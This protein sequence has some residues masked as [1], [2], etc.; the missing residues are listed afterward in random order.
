VPALTGPALVVAALLALAGAQKVLDPTM[1]VGA[2]QA[3]R[4]PASP[5]VVRI[6]AAA[7]LALGTAAIGLGGAALWALVAVSYLAFAAVVV[8]ALRRGTM[9]G[10]CGCFGREDT[11]PHWSHVG[12]NLTLASVA[13]GVAGRGDGAPL[14]AVF[15]HPGLG[16]VVVALA[17]VG[18]Y[19]L[20][21]LY[22]ELPRTLAAAR[23]ARPSSG[24]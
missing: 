4:L 18:V 7:E 8:A 21:A 22:V 14:D 1:T 12:L 5:L 6:G 23:T 2:L 11:P 17:A 19:L 9:I 24:H 16:A 10:S 13:L 15:D 3:L 20:Y